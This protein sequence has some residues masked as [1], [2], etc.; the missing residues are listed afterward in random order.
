MI[1]CFC[2]HRDVY[3]KERISACLDKAIALLISEG[4]SKFLLGG[5]GGFDAL[6]ARAV[7]RAKK[8]NPGLE[9][10]LVIPYLDRKYNAD[11]YDRTLYPELEQVPRRYAVLKRNEYMV[12]A[13]DVVLAYVTHDWG[14]AAQTVKYARRKKKRI[15]MLNENLE[16]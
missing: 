11:L 9:S 1:V 5:Y 8:D 14:G 16:A 3:Q 7:S 15:I 2:G 10:V 12:D 13:S 6:A 4:A